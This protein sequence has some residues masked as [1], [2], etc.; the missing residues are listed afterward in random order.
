MPGPG[1]I[2]YVAPS[3]L[4][5]YLPAATLALA[6]PEQ[7]MQACVDA[8]SEADAF[9][10]LAMP[11]LDWG[12]ELT[13]YTAYIAVFNLMQ[14]IG[15]APQDGSASL[16][17]RRYFMAVGGEVNGVRYDG[18]FP[19]VQR[20][21]INLENICTPS[22]PVSSDPTHKMPQVASNSPRGWQQFR[23]GRPVVGGN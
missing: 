6:T 3:Q 8:T 9:I 2:P 1:N 18:W 4:S 16:F 7:Q 20:H 14:T 19:R 10:D 23:N 12:A 22:I 11:L 5:Q 17:E 15:Y 13:K 21:A